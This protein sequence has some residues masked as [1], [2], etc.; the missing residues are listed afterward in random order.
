MPRYQIVYV[1]QSDVVKDRYSLS[2]RNTVTRMNPN[3][4]NLDLII[5]VLHLIDSSEQ[6]AHYDGAVLVFL[7][8][9]SHI[10]TLYQLLEADTVLGN[11][12]RY[13]FPYQHC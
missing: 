13:V 3:R 4:V 11:T 1:Y 7:P 2:V 9:L 10:Q 12:E 6:F 8:G 5:D